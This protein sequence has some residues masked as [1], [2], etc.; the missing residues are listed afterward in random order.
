MKRFSKQLLTFI[1]ISIALSAAFYFSIQ[2]RAVVDL[3][4]TTNAAT[5]LKIYWAS[6]EGHFSEQQSNK[7]YL[8]PGKTQYSLRIGN[9]ADIEKIRLDTSDHRPAELIL[10]H[11][12]ISQ[13][14]YETLD[15]QSEKDFAQFQVGGGIREIAIDQNGLHVTPDTQDPQL[16]LE[17][18][19]QV[20]SRPYLSLSIKYIII[21][22][23]VGLVLLVFDVGITDYEFV[24]Y[25]IFFVLALVMTMAVITKNNRHPD[26]YV[27]VAAAQYYRDHIAPPQ[28]GSQAI[29]DSYSVYGFSRLHSGEISYFVAGKYLQLLEPLHINKY[30]AARSFNILLLFV[31]FVLSL[32]R[33]EFRIFMLPVLMS[34]QVW[35]IFSY[36]NSDAF[37]LFVSLL[38]CYLLAHPKSI[39]HQYINNG[40]G[41]KDWVYLIVLS[42]L[43]A[44]LLLIKKNFYFLDLFLF[45]YFIWA[46]IFKIIQIN[47][48]VI[49]RLGFVIITGVGL[50]LT[51]WGADYMV[52][53]FDRQQRLEMAQEEFARKEFKPSTPI[54]QKRTTLSLKD[55]GVSLR[56]MVVDKKSIEK[57]FRSSFGNY[58]YTSITASNIYYEFLLIN[59][60]LLT[61]VVGSS[62]AFRGGSSTTTLLGIVVLVNLV[63][64]S[65]VV[66]HAWSVDYQLQGRYLL[67][68]IGMIAVLLHHSHR[69]IPQSLLNTLVGSMYLLSVYSFISVGLNEVEKYCG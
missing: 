19:Q 34:P 33:A 61:I 26:E 52:N 28:I 51:Y 43:F 13:P 47:R 32:K 1:L 14:G 50:F 31:L 40:F 57:I 12:K 37:A 68:A 23:L 65:T 46:V 62:I 59:V 42:S 22:L 63:M 29:K 30:Q 24:P 55:R 54:E 67:P 35:Y 4:L 60:I 53:N 17:I 3:S 41:G 5:T 7:V 10:K 44:C 58:G 38:M 18:P 9:I 25:L 6:S 2:A 21:L 45:L 69:L 56:E 15:F 36:F 8:H 66:H 64:I 11:V 20:Y 48:A 16:I 39:F 49:I 27:H